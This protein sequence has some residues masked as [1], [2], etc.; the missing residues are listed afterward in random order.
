MGSTLDTLRSAKGIEYGFVL[1][2]EG[3]EKLL[4]DRPDIAAC[5]TAYSGTD[6]ST[7]ITG[8]IPDAEKESRIEPWK[9]KVDVPI[10]R[11]KVRGT[12]KDDSFA[13]AVFAKGAGNET[14][15]DADFDS[16]DTTMTVKSTADFASSGTLYLGRET[17]TF[18]G[19]TPTTFTG[20]TRGK[21]S[22]FLTSSSANFGRDHALE[23]A[24]FGVHFRPVVTDAPRQW[25]A[26]TCALYIHRIVGG[27]WDVVAQARCAFAGTLTKIEDTA[28]LVTALTIKDIRQKIRDCVLL[29]DQFR[30]RLLQGLN[31]PEGWT[32]LAYEFDSP[33]ASGTETLTFK[34]SPSGVNEA[35]T[36][37]YTADEIVT[38]ISKWLADAMASAA[39]AGLWSI[40]IATDS[41]DTEESRCFITQSGMTGSVSGPE[42]Y[43]MVRARIDILRFLG[44]EDYDPDFNTGIGEVVQ[45][46]PLTNPNFEIVSDQQPIRIWP[47]VNGYTTLNIGQTRG[48]WFNNQA[49]LPGPLKS[50]TVDGEDWGVIAVG[51]SMY[52]AKH[53]SD[54]QFTLVKFNV[55]ESRG[56]TLASEN[57]PTIRIDDRSSHIEVRQIAIISG[58]FLD[59]FAR[60]FASTGTS[61]F[62]HPTYDDWPAMLGMGMSWGLLG[63][64]FLDSMESLEQSTAQSSVTLLIEKPTRLEE[65]LG[66]EMLLR[67]SWLLWKNEGLQFVQHPTPHSGVAVHT[68]T[69]DNKGVESG[70]NID[71]RAPVESSEQFIKN[72]I[73][74]EYNRDLKGVY[75]S[76]ITFKHQDSIQRLGPRPFTIKA[77]NAFDDWYAIDSGMTDLFA[78]V[79][80]YVATI[81]AMPVDVIRRTVDLNSYFGLYPADVATVT[82]DYV[83]DPATGLRGISGL[84]ALV[85]S[86]KSSIG[87]EEQGM[88]GTVELAFAPINRAAIYCPS[89]LIDATS[90]A[91]DTP[92]GGQSTITCEA[93]AFSKSGE[94]V[95]ASNFDTAGYGV[96]V[97]KRDDL[98]P[99]EWDA[100]VVSVSGDDVVLDSNLAGFDDSGATKYVLTFQGY[101]GAD[102]QAAQ[103]A[104]C[105]IADDSD[106]QVNDE[107]HAYTWAGWYDN[108][109]WVGSAL[110][111]LVERPGTDSAGVLSESD[112]VAT[113]AHFAAARMANSLTNLKTAPSGS[114][115]LPTA[116]TQA[117]TDDI[118]RLQFPISIGGALELQALT[119]KLYVSPM[120]KSSDGSDVFCI[121]TASAIPARLSS[122]TNPIMPTVSASTEFTFTSTSYAYATEVGLTLRH[123]P[124]GVIWLHVE[125]RASGGATCSFRGVAWRLGGLE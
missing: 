112:P 50:K 65:H 25:L 40:T 62:N 58:S 105:F 45:G 6:W 73:K 108:G 54:S 118:L 69:E 55:S 93:H 120:V 89:A 83:R 98:T 48:V 80:T 115:V 30:G 114:M 72:V 52:L 88:F 75:N 32:V 64:T 119:R 109:N 71:H 68:L 103:Q 44:F 26:R 39:L 70:S 84:P 117:G 28:D 1:V 42:S 11:F 63:D 21:Y 66:S 31:I 51:D 4:T 49:W 79:I 77:M 24:D 95:D 100:A 78:D 47:F 104:H 38:I 123:A 12:N 97:I 76:S 3:Y 16:D 81:W 13:E 125:L 99:T 37:T 122:H 35:P 94:A 74:I 60:I 124:T 15:L 59:V 19:K 111:Q 8:L 106:G 18:S 29:R 113:F 61:G 2:I 22:P 87:S 7:A 27:V 90:Y 43:I 9:A 53:V 101:D 107:R 56:I 110:S 41:G 36:G 116:L 57:L 5:A 67:G 82:D 34:D 85:L 14:L 23:D 17:M 20:I 86:T 96:R 92:I 121:I 91:A 33:S 46:S 102:I 10:R